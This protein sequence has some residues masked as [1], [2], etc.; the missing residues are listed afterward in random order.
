MRSSRLVPMVATALGS[1]LAA[2]PA[3][4]IPVE[5]LP[6]SRLVPL[7]PLRQPHTAGPVSFADGLTWR[8]TS[9][10]S[11]FG[12]TGRHNLGENGEWRGAGA[13]FAAL[14][15]AVGTMTIAFEQPVF[16]VGALLNHAP[17]AGPFTIAVYD[18]GMRLLESST[19]AFPSPCEPPSPGCVPSRTINAGEFHGFLRD[20]ASISY[21]T[22][23][24]AYVVMRGLRVSPVP[25]PQTW[26]LMGAGLAALAWRRRRTAR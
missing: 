2:A 17:P 20:S 11:S 22:L 23:S 24:D 25:E 3:S 10:A 4:A 12:D 1:L 26:V 21:F 19:L 15:S 6:G 18:A 7:P 8:S 5:S 14:G 16:G 13:P 9:A